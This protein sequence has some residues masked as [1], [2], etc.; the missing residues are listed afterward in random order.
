MYKNLYILVYVHPVY[1]QDLYILVYL[2]PV[3]LQ[4]L[5]PSS[6]CTRTCIFEY[7]YYLYL[8][9]KLYILVH[10]HPLYVQ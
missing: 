7:M 1:V 4:E 2:H 8:Y 6:L 5:I 9:K 3:Y 10:L